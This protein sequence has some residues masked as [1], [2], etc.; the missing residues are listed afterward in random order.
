MHQH[1]L[2]ELTHLRSRGALCLC[3][4]LDFCSPSAGAVGARAC[5]AAALS[6]IAAKAAE[7]AEE[8]CCDALE[9][10]RWDCALSVE[11]TAS[12]DSVQIKIEPFLCISGTSM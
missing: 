4:S 1:H 7:A 5:D 12:A 9:L 8:A 2:N 6:A 11:S 3:S 10:A